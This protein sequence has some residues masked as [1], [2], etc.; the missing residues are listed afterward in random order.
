MKHK[1]LSFVLM[2]TAMSTSTLYA[3][4]IRVSGKVTSEDG[5]ALSN[6]TVLI[7]NGSKATQ[8]DSSGNYSMMAK[9]NDVLIF[10]SIGYADKSVKVNGTKSLNVQLQTSSTG[11][12][13][14]IVTAYGKQNKEAI[15]GAV[16]S[17]SAKDIEKRPVSSVTAVLE[18]AAP[19]IMV[20]N[21]NGEPGSNPEVRIRGFGTVNGDAS[22]TY[23]VDGVVF[24]GNISDINPADIASV[25]VL[26]DATS[27][28]L[29]GSRAANGVI[30]IT[31]KNGTSGAPELNFSVNQGLFTRGIPEYDKMDERQFMEAAWQGLRN[32]YLW[33][34]KT[35]TIDKANE[36]ANKNLVPTILSLNIFDKA[37]DKL[38][39]SNG[40]L[41][42]TAKIKGSY[43]SDLDWFKPLSR[44]GYRQDY[45]LNGRGGNEKGNY[46]FNVGYLNE[47]GYIKTSDFE[48]LSGRLSANITPRSWVSAGFSANASHQNSNNTTGEGSGFTNPWNF[49]RNIAP[50]YP[51]HLHDAVTG[52]FV[53]DADKNKIYDNGETS[54][55]QY[56]GRHVIWENELNLNRGLRNTFNSQAY[57]NF[58][59]LKDFEFK[60]VGDINL[61]NTM[62]KSY[63]NAIIGDG[64]GNGGRAS[65]TVYNYKN[66][67]VQQQL[68]YNKTINGVHN[69]DVFL[70]HEN[71]GYAYNYLYGYKTKQTF[72]GKPELINFNEITSLTDYSYDKTLDAY[73]SRV[74][75]NYDGKYFIEGAFRRDGTSQVAPDY[76]YSNFWSVGGS[77]MVSKEKFLENEK[78]INSLKL[79]A[80]TGY[81]GNLA[82][83]G[84]YDYMDL[85]TI[86]QNNNNPALYKGNIGN[87]QLTWE[88]NQ[89][90]SFA[91]EGRLFNRMNFV[92]EYFNKTSKDLIFNVN[93]ASSIGSANNDGTTTVTRNIGAL[94]NKGIELTFDVDIIK[95]QDFRWNFGTNATFFKNKITKMPEENKANGLLNSPFKYME[96][97]SVYDFFLYQFAGVDMITGQS[98][99]FADSDQFDPTNKTG[100]WYEF[101]EEI[102]GVMY[103]RN[104][105]YSKRD[106]SGSAIP[107][108]MG[109]FNT[110][111]SYKNFNLTGLFTYSIGG[112]G[113]DYSYIDLMSLGSTPSA[114]HQ[115]LSKAWTQ[116]PEGMTLTSAN[117]INPDAIPQVN[118][119]NSAF[120]NSSIS[121]R[122]LMNSSY[123]SIKNISLGYQLPQTL[124]Q[125]MDVRR[126]NLFFTVENLATFTKLKGFSPQQGFDGISDN[127]FVPYRTFS[128][129]VNIGL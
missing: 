97:H 2:S 14:V 68:T 13:E 69:L 65:R 25:S 56:G 43:A 31:T 55:N 106:W 6:V 112:K 84:Y 28:A 105:A 22:P 92:V 96:G 99:Y 117:R 67:T 63:N 45:S 70:G 124:L 110:S 1:L 27:A 79:R 47:E 48:R 64:T 10:R 80:A 100:A 66:Y 90:T 87:Q 102:N 59:F 86:G 76:R 93:L 44:K 12:E 83:L 51:V 58:K 37:D 78:W 74:R 11:L 104:A 16:S 114:L 9:S 126:L 72:A 62:S 4:E 82:S 125:K 91:L 111:F 29:Y 40:K 52:D 8:T 50:I 108:L 103:T 107:D 23:V 123:L 35:W 121:N 127:E 34:N 101:Q 85:Y 36:E 122:F 128:L 30:V 95:N 18:G 15:V 129:G 77:W 61:R 109:S 41:D 5:A 113:L 118:F 21:S 38:F 32:Q 115:D 53:L 49:A 81:V 7:Q 26:K 75:Y 39:D 24:G 88:A 42:A 3:Q 19:G 116:A 119:K 98:L 60:I 89:S 120:N 17:I 73:L 33:D 71:Y 20:N 94:T 46:M 57:I 54:R